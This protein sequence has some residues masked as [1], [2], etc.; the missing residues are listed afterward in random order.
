MV[1][2]ALGI[3]RDVSQAEF[4]GLDCLLDLAKTAIRQAEAFGRRRS[5]WTRRLVGSA[6]RSGI[7]ISKPRRALPDHLVPCFKSALIRER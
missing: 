4:I 3:A 1:A 7:R 2:R 5:E 6:A